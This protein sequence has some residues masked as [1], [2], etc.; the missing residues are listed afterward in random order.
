LWVGVGV[1]IFSFIATIILN[2]YDEKRDLEENYLEN[3]EEE[4]DMAQ[5]SFNSIKQ[6][7]YVITISF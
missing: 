1:C 4:E 3:F 2:H 7:S 6:L 5:S